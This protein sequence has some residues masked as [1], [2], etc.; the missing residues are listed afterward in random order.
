MGLVGDRYRLDRELGTGGTA[1]VWLARDQ[2]AE[3]AVAVKVVVPVPLGG[4]ARRERLRT[5]ARV[6]ASLD[7]PNVVRVLDLGEHDGRDYIVMEYFERGSLADRLALGGPMPPG[8]AVDAALQV[9]AGLGAA[10]DAGVVHRDVKPGNVLVRDDGTVALCDFGI[11]RTALGSATE[12]GVALGSIGFMAPE[13]RLDARRAGPQADLYATACTLFNLVTN[14]TPVDLYLAPDTSPRW[15]AVP[16]G[17]RGVLRQA[18]RSEPSQRFVSAPAMAEALRAV[19]PSVE[20]LPALRSRHNH[21]P[22][23]GYVPTSVPPRAVDPLEPEPSVRAEQRE[24]TVGDD[25][26]RWAHGQRAPVGRPAVWIG[27]SVMGLATLVG[28]TLGPL[29]A[30]DHAYRPA[31]EV[32]VE[33]PV[34]P[35]AP[36]PGAPLAPAG[37]WQGM[38]GEAHRATLVLTGPPGAL[39]GDLVMRLGRHE[40]HSKVRGEVRPDGVLSLSDETGRPAGTTYEARPLAGGLVLEGEMVRGEEPPVPFALVRTE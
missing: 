13:Q 34:L 38:F 2:R 19:R 24:R 32:P 29:S 37:T 33:A 25:D 1:T 26:W 18:T 17:L 39:R 10:H 3:R 28:L 27:A 9:L 31:E 14:D 8:E 35:T 16:Q 11:A 21:S 22:L 20:A 6:L 30:G 15:D 40:L 7:H 36:P 4:A 23:I 12:T 5:E